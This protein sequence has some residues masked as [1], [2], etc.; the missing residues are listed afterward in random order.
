VK[1]AL[2]WAAVVTA[3]IA[4]LR[5]DRVIE[6]LR[7]GSAV[8]TLLALTMLSLPVA[9]FVGWKRFSHDPSAP[10][11]SPLGNLLRNGRFTVGLAIVASLIAAAVLAPVLSSFAPHVQI[12]LAGAARLAPSFEHPFGTDNF[13]RDVLSRVLHGARYSLSVA[14][15][16]IGLAITLGTMVGLV[17]GMSGGWLDSA[18]MRCVDAGLAIP[19]LFFLLVIIALW[20][21]VSLGTLVLVIGLTGWFG[22]SRLVRAEVLSLR[23]REYIVAARAI[24]VG[25]WRL[26][27]RYLL[28]NIASPIIVTAALGMG[29]IVLIEAGLSYLGI[30]VRVPTPS[31]GNIIRDGHDL[32]ATA[33]WIS[34]A[35]GVAIV[36]TVLGFS[37]VG[38]GL[39]SAL[40]PRQR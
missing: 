5:F 33:P 16:S 9:A 7:S 22:T 13:S 29:N 3:A 40:N 18:L 35:P 27:R 30:G 10:P 14:V 39:Q 24:G 32:L 2:L 15:L 23:E 17:A 4:A 25:R 34:I 26:V 31:W 6:L 36:L 37:L 12:D 28:P 8:D 38:D 21:T 20:D 11:E 1:R 19:R